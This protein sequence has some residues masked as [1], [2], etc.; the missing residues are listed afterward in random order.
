VRSVRLD[1]AGHTLV[2][3][4]SGAAHDLATGGY[5]ER[6]AECVAACERLGIEHLSAA[7][8]P[9]VDSLPDPLRLR[10]EHVLTENQRVRETARALE[11]GDLAQVG[12]LLDAGHASLRDLYA[13]SVPEVE[14]AVTRLKKAG[15]LGARMV[16]GG[17]GGSVLALFAPGASLPQDAIVVAP[18]PPAH[19]A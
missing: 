6:H 17:F 5:N 11:R 1:L 8:A 19:V 12:A 10:A 15:A 18:G 7:T 3:V 16:G 2:T 4:D 9:Q 14:A 13:A